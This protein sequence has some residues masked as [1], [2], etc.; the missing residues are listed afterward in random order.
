MPGLVQ[1]ST[2][3]RILLD[4]DLGGRT[5]RVASNPVTV[6]DQAG[7]SWQY[8]PG[9]DYEPVGQAVGED[10]RRDVVLV[11]VGV[12]WALLQA[13]G[14]TLAQRRAVLRLHYDGQLLEECRTLVDGITGQITV[15]LDELA[16]TVT[17]G[18]W[19]RSAVLPVPTARV[20][21]ATWTA[22]G[23]P[24]FDPPAD[25]IGLAYQI[26][27]GYP[28]NR[29]QSFSGSGVPEPA[30]PVIIAEV[31]PGTSPATQTHLFADGELNASQ[32]Q[33][34]NMDAVETIAYT[35]VVADD[36]L[37]RPVTIIRN[38]PGY[39]VGTELW[40]GLQND[41]T[42]GGGLEWE[43]QVLRGLGDVIRWVYSQSRVPYDEGAM[44]AWGEYLNRYKVD[45]Y[46]NTP[47]SLVAWLQTEI[48]SSVQVMQVQGPRGRY[49]V[50]LRWWATASDAVAHLDMDAGDW[51]RTAPLA[52][53]D[54][55]IYNEITVDYRLAQGDRYVSRRV[56]TAD[57][58]TYLNSL[59]QPSNP[60]VPWYAT[61]EKDQRVIGS[62]LAGKSQATYGPRPMTMGLSW[63]WDDSTAQLLGSDM[64]ERM[65]WPKRSTQLQGP[66]WAARSLGVGDVVLISESGMHL[67]ERPA[68]VMDVVTDA[69]V[70]RVDVVL[71]DRPL[72]EALAT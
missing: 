57:G 3:P 18:E 63:T 55:P 15:D 64:L 16:F 21:T 70:T 30:V 42:F 10:D 9:L 47:T 66:A 59:G 27:I 36:G 62:G 58:Q 68:L 50:P 31:D 53:L 39:D 51:T 26:V 44:R 52:H 12:D 24:N 69:V 33:L 32:I 43:G 46:I 7:A 2:R 65:A 72:R 4:L 1:G 14:V 61:S 54:D 13:R 37:G 8:L 25:T 29:E 34:W 17:A 56:L 40:Y 41:S 71:L 35:P 20:D 11:G 22:V 23:G 38:Q 67:T 6:S 28:G 60:L 19:Q 49:Y 48:L 45:T 5:L